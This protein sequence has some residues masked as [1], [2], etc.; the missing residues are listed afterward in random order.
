MISGAF[1]ADFSSFNAA[2]EGA[3]VKLRSFEGGSE[4]VASQLSRMTDS[5]SGRQIIQQA[6]LMAEVFDRAGHGAGLTTAELERMGSVGAAA[7][8]KLTAT[9]GVV[10][11]KLQAMADA[12][13]GVAAP[14]GSMADKFREF[15]GVLGA[16]GIHLHSEISGLAD[17]GAA[18]GKS[19]GEIGLVGI[20]GLAVGAGIAGWKIGRA[21]AD[22]FD[23]DAKVGAATAK[24]LGF[25]DVAAQ[26]AGA[27]ADVLAR[28]SK[29]AGMAIVD[30]DLAMA[31]NAESQV[32]WKTNV[33]IS[34]TAIAGWQGKLD[35][36]RAA[37]DLP[38]LTKDL[39][40]QNFTLEDLAERYHVS[41]AALQYFQH[42]TAAAATADEAAT[43]RIQTSNATKL[44]AL[45]AE[46]AAHKAARE[47]ESASLLE[48]TKLEEQYT[49]TRLKE[50]GTANEIEIGAIRTK[51]ALQKAELEAN[52]KLTSAISAQ[53]AKDM[54]QDLAGVGIDW[55]FLREHAVAT[56]NETA[57]N[58]RATYEEMTAHA[59]NFSREGIDVQRQKMRDAQDEAR[60]LGKAWQDSQAAAKAATEKQNVEL[61]KQIE[62]AKLLRAINRDMGNTTEI[63][64]STQAGRDKVDPAIAR[65]LHEGYS[66]AQASAIAYDL[67]WNIPI[68]SNDPL[69]RTKGPRVPGFAEGGTV[70]VGEN[71]PEVVRLPF[72]SQV[73][74][75]GSGAGG[76]T[77]VHVNLNVS[78]VLDPRTIRELTAGV[79]TELVA[80][81]LAAGWRP[82]LAVRR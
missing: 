1:A 21:A 27:R 60:G 11:A 4:K 5:F 74:P 2:V 28:A 68:N 24:L 23:L 16:L 6:T 67:A 33:E 43:A 18:S 70:M 53:M 66:L 19:A 35:E 80:G 26:V 3:Q 34:A 30:L 52:H 8:E 13:K 64:T 71:G 38:Q 37:G 72:G 40:S 81:L 29:T 14:A 20:A 41:V 79:K 56:L 54:A 75:N 31:I 59:S 39:Q 49:Q 62:E 78:G 46:L 10:T 7:I 82:P 48:L 73:F 32:K 12:T 25:G 50:T 76:D 22:F 17:L 69:F 61:A 55:T 44:H 42:E 9:G 57:A 63:D 51:Y 36:V 15:D 58:A 65:W 77:T 47:L 45:A